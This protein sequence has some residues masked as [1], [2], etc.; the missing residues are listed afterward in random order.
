M[1]GGKLIAKKNYMFKKS[2]PRVLQLIKK[3]GDRLV[4]FGDD[5]E[6]YAIMGFDEYERLAIGKEKVSDLTEDQLLDKINRDIAAWKAEQSELG[7]ANISEKHEEILSPGADILDNNPDFE[8]VWDQA[9]F[10]DEDEETKDDDMY[11]LEKV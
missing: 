7:L 3:T 9:A 8:E 6:P 1:G 5:G 2:L 4:V 11:Y 10:E